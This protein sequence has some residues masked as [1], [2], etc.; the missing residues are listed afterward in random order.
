[1]G[2]KEKISFPTKILSNRYYLN[3]VLMEGK[4]TLKFN[5]R[6]GYYDLYA[7]QII[8][9]GNCITLLRYD[10]FPFAKWIELRPDYSSLT[11]YIEPGADG[12]KIDPK[13]RK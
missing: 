7:A 1:M 13:G 4:K 12:P 11:G 2:K 10:I 5:F 6:I 8:R 3:E 9:L